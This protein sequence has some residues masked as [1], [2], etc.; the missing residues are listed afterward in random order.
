MV[1]CGRLRSGVKQKLNRWKKGHSSESNPQTHR[2]REAARSRFFSRPSANSDLTVDALKLHNE[3]QT[4]SLS[5]G[6]RACSS[7]EPIAETEDNGLTE[8]TSGTF[9]SGL[10]DCSNLTFSR[11]QRF[12]ESNSAAHKEICAVLAAVTEVI[13]SQG[14]KETETE[15]FAAL[16]TTLEAVESEESVAAIVYLLSLV[17]KR[18]PAPVLKKKFSDTAKVFMNLV[19]IQAS[20][21]S[22][23]ALRWTVSCLSTLLRRQDLE[24]WSFPSTLQVYHGLLSFAIHV[25]PKVR[26][27]AQ[28]GICSILKGSDFMFG[29]TSPSLHP[30]A[31]ST[32]KFCIQ[33]IEKCGGSTENATTL[34]VLCL[35]KEVLPCFPVSCVKSCCE[36]LLRVMT[37]S[38]VMVTACSM[39][40]FHGL[41]AAKPC[42]STLT[43]ELN[44]QIITA[45][46][47]YL[48]SV[49][50]LQ[51]MLAWLTVMEKAH[52]NLSRL[53][54]LLSLAH[55][56]RVFSTAVSCLL[57][58]HT[59][60]M[61]AAADTMKVLLRECVTPFTSDIG[62]FGSS[63]P[64]GPA[65]YICKMFRAV[66]DGLAYRFYAAWAF[67]LQV[68]STFFEVIGSQ[69]Y[70]AMKQCLKTLCDLRATQHF[71]CVV[72]LEHAVG[73]AVEKMGPE[74]VLQAVPLQIDGTEEQFD[75]PRSWLIPV[76]RDHVKHTQLAFFNKYFLPLAAKLKNRALELAEAGQ[77]LEAKIYDTLQW[78]IWT[79]LPG[80][81]TK[82]TDTAVAFQS[83][84][85]TLG[86]AISD[87]P[88]LRPTVCQ[89]LRVLI[90]KGCENDT[91]QAE[92]S[93]FAKNFLPILFNVYCTQPENGE[94]P[95]NRL[96]VLDTIKAYLSI[97]DQQLVCG[98]LEKAK[99]K[100]EN[101]ESSEFT[102]LSVMDLLVAMA[103]LVDEASM[104]HIYQII[105]LFLQS[106]GHSMQKKAY[107]ILEV[108]CGGEQEPCRQFVHQ[109]LEELKATLLQSLKT[110]ASPAKRPRLK[111]LIH[112]VKKLSA[113]HQDFIIALLPE[114]IICMK[115]VSIGARRNGYTLL[116]EIGQAFMRFHSDPQMAIKE[117]LAL[118]YAGLTGSVTMISCTVLALTRLVFEFKDKMDVP[119][120]EQLLKN[121]CLLLQS[122]T[123]DVVKSALSFI[124]VVLFIMDT[125]ALA[126]QLQLLMES[127]G[128]MR[129][130]SRRHF[131]MKIKNIFTKFI[132]KFGF[133]MIDSMVPEEYHKVLVNIRK[134]E[135][136]N[137]RQRARKQNASELESEDETPKQSRD[138]IEDILA[139]T[140][141]EDEGIEEKKAL[142][143]QP[144]QKKPAWLKEGGD[145]EPLNFLDP[146]VSQRVLA[147]NPALR[148]KSN[149]KHDYSVTPDGR[150]IISEGP[151]DEQM[152][153]SED[154]ANE[155]LE[156]V[157]AKSKVGQKQRFKSADG[158][159]MQVDCSYKAGGSG[160]H[161]PRPMKKNKDYGAEY[162]AVKG[163]GDMKKKGKHDPFAYVPLN[164]AQLNRRNKAKVSG[165]FKGLVKTKVTSRK[166]HRKKK[167][168]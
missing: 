33:E 61:S 168:K 96:P 106:K 95:A 68:L 134:A 123:R 36:T 83:V 117:Y 82:P 157:G 111:C 21:G 94:N 158:D 12:W 47:D 11:V 51:P 136:R 147:T 81:C 14:G 140:D 156:E 107:R 77:S 131:R 92:V 90:S 164:K 162:R 9:L 119:T 6:P 28:R 91:D 74:T 99:E 93:R 32:A 39:Q 49:N 19:S 71:P 86:M 35:L 20:K 124:K 45:L 16:M 126:Q 112:I 127:I 40:A 41:F 104:G 67:V 66:E 122:K 25:K 167:T 141:S 125:S 133:D 129:D 44:A 24:M 65:S 69:A 38:N 4:N 89:A 130:D 37:L 59:Q 55:L 63:S 2:F 85:R 160:I 87:R 153:D 155:I 100:L 151:R 113:E 50:D 115:E 120:I 109:H 148:K 72:E 138:S 84:A 26:K 116:V 53:Q 42:S 8:K 7:E 163:Q 54:G 52:I 62:V 98:F 64:S 5:M 3:L 80:F 135:A 15:Y 150:L 102:R 22:P 18:V 146:Q 78:Q 101:S 79:M 103:P 30:A 60:L 144:V 149:I 137:K 105:L 142:K 161:R 34:H 43:A 46:Y 88:D 57:S 121:V 29:D 73:M 48:P 31:Q 118:V 166:L 132:R 145:D 58:P 76:I 10:S 108:I 143:K 114:V 154:E 13:R 70:P 1:R 56:P 152:N 165:Q 17:V 159:D 97:A 139:E 23:V 128:S 75:F 110:A 27:E